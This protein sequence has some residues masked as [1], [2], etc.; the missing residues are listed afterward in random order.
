MKAYFDGLYRGAYEVEVVYD[1]NRN[2]SKFIDYDE[3]IEKVE[4]EK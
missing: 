4:K 1:Y 3:A 2:F